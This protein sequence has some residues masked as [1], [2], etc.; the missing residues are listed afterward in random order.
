[1]PKRLLGLVPLL[2]LAACATP[3]EPYT[4]DVVDRDA[5]TADLAACQ[6]KAEAYKPG[7]D[8]R[9]IGAAG[10]QGAASNAA[11]AVLNPLVPVA[12]ALGNSFSTLL[13][14]LGLLNSDRKKI[15]ARC[16]A[17]KGRSSGAYEVIDPNE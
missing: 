10:V 6:A 13:S 2:L 5:Y 9:T 7:L 8:L 15:T 14:Q 1:M 12:G 4:P 16:M 17:N 3:Y 11:T